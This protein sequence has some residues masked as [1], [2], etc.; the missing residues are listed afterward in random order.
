MNPL[1]IMIVDDDATFAKA[2]QIRL[3]RSFPEA[4]KIV[5]VG[6]AEEAIHEISASGPFDVMILDYVIPGM[7][8]MTFL[9][10]LRAGGFDAAVI[11]VSAREEYRI[12]QSF[13]RH[14]ADDF[15]AKGEMFSATELEQ[16]I[17]AVLEKREKESRAARERIAKER[18]DAI[19]TLVQTVH[20][21]MNNP[22][23]V[24]KLVA[25]AI[26]INREMPREK[27]EE[28]LELI[29]ENVDRTSAIVEKLNLLEE[30]P[31][32]DG[33][34]GPQTYDVPS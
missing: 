27:L 9:E 18:I 1:N 7:S 16:A 21:E 20:H 23:A 28:Y 29:L 33:K 22:L 17:R 10:Q 32:R 2:M 8:G 4:R 31:G 34:Q 6:S 13:L 14:G 25:S 24:L 12:V 19:Q 26:R 30:E 11:C 15:L 5:I 3:T